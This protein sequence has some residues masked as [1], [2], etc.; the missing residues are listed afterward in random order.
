MNCE[1]AAPNRPRSH[2]EVLTQNSPQ[3]GTT[4]WAV[5]IAG[6]TASL[7]SQYGFQDET[8]SLLSGTVLVEGLK[9]YYLFLLADSLKRL[10]PWVEL[11][12]HDICSQFWQSDI[13]V[14][15]Q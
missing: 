12:Y 1:Y 13:I 5:R 11:T 8:M 10:K 4:D 6:P 9:N 7:L 14:I 3:K 2:G 15:G